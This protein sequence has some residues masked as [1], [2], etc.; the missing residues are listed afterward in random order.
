VASESEPFLTLALRESGIAEW[1]TAREVIPDQQFAVLAF[2]PRLISGPPDIGRRFMVAYLQGVRQY[3]RGKTRR[4]V[5]L[6]VKSTGLQEDLVRQACWPAMRDD[7]SINLDRVLEFQAWAVKK[8]LQDRVVPPERFWDGRFTSH[9]N[10]EL[11]GN[12][13]GGDGRP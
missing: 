5:D 3:N 1:K 9:A 4:N 13:G 2:G 11:S 6:L 7:G 10:K 12:P 8:G